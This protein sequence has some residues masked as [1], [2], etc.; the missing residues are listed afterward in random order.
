MWLSGFKEFLRIEVEKREISLRRDWRLGERILLLIL[1]VFSSFFF[2]SYFADHEKVCLYLYLRF[3]V[4]L[5]QCWYTLLDDRLL[6][7]AQGSDMWWGHKQL[8]KSLGSLQATPIWD[9]GSFPRRLFPS[10]K[11]PVNPLTYSVLKFSQ[12]P[13]RHVQ[14]ESYALPL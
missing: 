3:T 2:S 5:G 8:L 9:G 7:R 12:F 10:D 13:S 14:R 1:G 4:S 6:R 11:K